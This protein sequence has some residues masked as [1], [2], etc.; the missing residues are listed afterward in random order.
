MP[1]SRS[2]S[3]SIQ[4]SDNLSLQISVCFMLYQHL[5]V[6]STHCPI[7]AFQSAC[8]IVISR[9]LDGVG[10]NFLINIILLHIPIHLMELDS[11]H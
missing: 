6:C 2:Q 1:S 5:G 4:M 3:A 7:Q 8:R 9:T 10:S 11:S